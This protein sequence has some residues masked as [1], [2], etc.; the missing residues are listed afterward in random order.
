M[1]FLQSIH[2]LVHGNNIFKS[3][4]IYE[5]LRWI[6]KHFRLIFKRNIYFIIPLS[7]FKSCNNT[8]WDITSKSL[9]RVLYLVASF[10]Q[11]KGYDAQFMKWSV[12]L[13]KMVRTL[14]P[15]LQEIS[16]IK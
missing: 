11:L 14:I 13:K 3:N 8:I 12:S 1:K 2:I 15:V 6:E 7:L 5:L 9:A 10:I 16:N 4:Y